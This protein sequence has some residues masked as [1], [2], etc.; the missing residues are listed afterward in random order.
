MSSYIDILH[1]RMRKRPTVVVQ[2]ETVDTTQK[3]IVDD[4]IESIVNVES[5]PIPSAESEPVPE[6]EVAIVESELEITE[7][8]EDIQAP[9]GDEPTF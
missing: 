8:V 9:P 2:P 6:C 1:S 3:V 4:V 7:V 5:I